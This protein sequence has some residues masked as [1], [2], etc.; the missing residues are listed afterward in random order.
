M[1]LEKQEELRNT[2]SL[3]RRGFLSLRNAI[4]GLVI[5]KATGDPFFD[6]NEE[7]RQKLLLVITRRRYEQPKMKSAPSLQS[8]VLTRVTC[9]SR[10]PGQNRGSLKSQ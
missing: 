4:E 2:Y 6:S 8:T 10:R 7:A 3:I 1:D 9:W 5:M